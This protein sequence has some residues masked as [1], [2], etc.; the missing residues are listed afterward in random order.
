MDVEELKGHIAL[1]IAK[2][3]DNAEK[4]EKG[5]EQRESRIEDKTHPDYPGYTIHRG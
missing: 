1:L 2:M 5:E 3:D 4:A